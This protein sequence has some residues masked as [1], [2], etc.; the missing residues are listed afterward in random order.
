M[1]NFCYILGMKMFFFRP[2]LLLV[3]VD[4][5]LRRA[6]RNSN[7]LFIFHEFFFFLKISLI[8][9]YLPW[10]K[11]VNCFSNSSRGNFYNVSC[12]F[13]IVTNGLLMEIQIIISISNLPMYFHFRNYITIFSFLS[14]SP[15][16]AP[17]LRN[18]LIS[19]IKS[20][21]SPAIFSLA[22]LSALKSVL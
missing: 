22:P 5:R 7:L 15:A 20:A 14:R 19:S 17:L 3:V 13:C 21:F 6:Y 2:K 18:C 12:I 11:L 4:V 16:A 8:K 9:V 1:G 10:C